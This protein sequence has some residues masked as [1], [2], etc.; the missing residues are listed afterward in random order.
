MSDN[1]WTLLEQDAP[2]GCASVQELYSWSLNYDASSG[3][4]A[5][6]LDII[7]LSADRYGETFA[8]MSKVS[9]GY[10]EADKLGRALVEYSNSPHAVT[11]YAEALL[12]AGMDDGERLVEC[13]ACE[14]RS[15]SGWGDTGLCLVCEGRANVCQEHAR[16]FVGSC[17]LNHAAL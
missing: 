10:V 2:T 13:G 5:L 6:F 1:I 3:P 12:D 14:E 11:I 9:L 15:E 7:G 8:D 17:P 4:F 16:T